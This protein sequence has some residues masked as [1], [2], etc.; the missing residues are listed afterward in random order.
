MIFFEVFSLLKHSNCFLQRV[1]EYFLSLLYVSL[2]SRRRG[3]GTSQECSCEEQEAG[4]GRDP[5]SYIACS[6]K[7]MQRNMKTRACSV[8]SCQRGDGIHMRTEYVKWV[9]SKP[10]GVL[11]SGEVVLSC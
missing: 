3:Q 5:F 1:R 4:W 11:C 7:A 6:L 10:C 8:E 9:S 2:S